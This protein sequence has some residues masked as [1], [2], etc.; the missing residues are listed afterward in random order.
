[1]IRTAMHHHGRTFGLVCAAWLVTTIGEAHAQAPV[2]PAPA[3]APPPAAPTPAATA[4]APA[5]APATSEAP[6]PVYAPPSAPSETLPA[7]P[8]PTPYAGTQ[9]T[10]PAPGAYPTPG[11]PPQPAP[12]GFDFGGQSL[13]PL[14]PP[15]A[16]LDP[17][18]INPQPWRG[19]YWF[20][21]RLLVTGPLG[22]EV[23]A[24]PNL[25]TISGGADFGVRIH[26]ILGL[27]MGLSGHAQNRVRAT[28][29]E[30]GG[31]E[32]RVLTAT[33]LYW[34]ALFARIYA[35]VRKRFQ[36]YVD[37][38]GGLSRVDRA[39]EGRVYG[40]QMRLG[41]GFDG[42]ITRN[43]TLGVAGVYRLNALN[44][45]AAG[46]WIVGHAMH[47]VVELGFHW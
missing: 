10:A 29:M 27:G 21:A 41:L 35:P 46:R 23:P 2:I 44:D 7:T 37:V 33:A 12:S 28:V 38:G 36:P 39:I 15:P 34:D 9:P 47:G 8:A 42:W 43:V 16:R 11:A 3:T 18:R 14:P 26:N 32:K 5:T 13:T 1:M 40:A 30:L 31:N 20:G 24:R 4:P 19:R 45:R 25:L 6:A 22:G 17:A